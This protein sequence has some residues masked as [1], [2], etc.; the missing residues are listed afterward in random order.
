MTDFPEEWKPVIGYENIYA[1]SNCGRVKRVAGSPQTPKDRILKNCIIKDGYLGV[2]LCKGNK[3][4]N[5]SQS[6]ISDIT[7]GRTWRHI[8]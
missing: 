4:F 7:R 1:I 3:K 2:S 8:I 6:T 5:V